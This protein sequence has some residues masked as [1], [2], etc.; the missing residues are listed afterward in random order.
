MFNDYLL[1]RKKKTQ[2]KLKI[3]SKKRTI[4]PADMVELIAD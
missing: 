4:H 1:S 2:K 3:L